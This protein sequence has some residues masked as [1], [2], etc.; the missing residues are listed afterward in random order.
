MSPVT[1]AAPTAFVGDDAAPTAFVA[2]GC[3]GDGR[4][5]GQAG[6]GQDI[7]QNAGLAADVVDGGWGL[8]GAGKV[9]RG[10]SR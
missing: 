8:R 4:F 2:L 1:E 7:G 6:R 9:G 5:V 10:R 3:A